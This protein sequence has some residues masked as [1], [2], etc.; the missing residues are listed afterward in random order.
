MCKRVVL[1]FRKQLVS[2]NK[3]VE[4]REAKREVGSWY[5]AFVV[6]LTDM[7]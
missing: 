4:R 7:Q 6:Q 1:Q 3:K 5:E 2:I